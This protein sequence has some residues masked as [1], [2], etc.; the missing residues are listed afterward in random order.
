MTA[1]KIVQI[2]NNNNANANSNMTC[3]NCKKNGHVKEDCFKLKRKLEK[4]SVNSPAEQA[5][6]VLLGMCE[7]IFKHKDDSLFYPNEDIY[8]VEDDFFDYFHKEEV[9]FA[10]GEEEEEEIIFDY[11]IYH[12]EL[13]TATNDQPNDRFN[14]NTWLCDSA[15]TSHMKNSIERMTKLEPHVKTII[16]GE[17]KEIYSTHIGTFS[18]LATQKDGTTSTVILKDT[19]LV[20]DLWL[21]S[22]LSP[23][24]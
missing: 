6:V 15:V 17:G 1:I 5:E 8:P 18:A 20:P 3:F 16:V 4:E 24:L 11:P 19:Y 23:R 2:K 12:Q 14:V 7:E 21:I 13:V 9:V 22:S 10:Y